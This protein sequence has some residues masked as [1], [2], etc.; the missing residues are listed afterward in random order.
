MV[1]LG[2]ECFF[3][4]PDESRA[5]AMYVGSLAGSRYYTFKLYLAPKPVLIGASRKAVR[6]APQ[7][8]LINIRYN[9]LS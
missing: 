4:S 1:F 8:S 6:L 7:L 9:P 5:C 3:N 2:D